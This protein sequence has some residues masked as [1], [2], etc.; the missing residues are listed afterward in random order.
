MR[1]ILTTAMLAVCAI[2]LASC[3]TTTSTSSTGS[4]SGASAKPGKKHS[5][6]ATTDNTPHVGPHGHVRVDALVWRLRNVK[7][8]K[9]IQNAISPTRADGV[10]IIATLQVHSVKDQS[11][12]MSSDV[13]KLKDGNRTYSTSDKGETAVMING[14]EPF[15]LRDIRPDTT[16]SGKAVFDVPPGVLRRHPKLQFNELGFGSTHGY[17]A[18]PSLS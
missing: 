3:A 2:A 15:L 11:A 6:T 18:L 4:D 13:V 14:D 12:T 16:V 1:R 5:T 7:V 8:T 9:T 17:V 10:F